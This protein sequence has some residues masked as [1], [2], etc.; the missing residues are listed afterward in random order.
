MLRLSENMITTLENTDVLVNIGDPIFHDG[1]Y[2]WTESFLEL[3]GNCLRAPDLAA[4]LVS[5]IQ[6]HAAYRPFS[7]NSNGLCPAGGDDGLPPSIFS[8]SP[9]DG[10]NSVGLN[11]N[12]MLT[13]SK[14]V[15][16]STGN[17]TIRKMSDNSTVESIDV[18]SGQV[19]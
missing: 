10:V 2:P 17:I 16:A 14:V 19:T 9:A 11:A 7:L 18:T 13:F 6:A 8:L 15:T 3:N 5:W 1:Q 12:L 4:P